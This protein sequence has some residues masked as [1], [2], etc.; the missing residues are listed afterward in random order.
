MSEVITKYCKRCRIWVSFKW[1]C[2]W[3]VLVFLRDSVKIWE[4]DKAN[5]TNFQIGE[6]TTGTP[7]GKCV[8]ATDPSLLH[9]LSI[10]AWWSLFLIGNVCRVQ[11]SKYS[12][13]VRMNTIDTAGVDPC[14][15]LDGTTGLSSPMQSIGVACFGLGLLSIASCFT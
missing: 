4:M 12:V 5:D 6:P 15:C 9:W 1:L 3:P 11:S 2:W 14:G 7:R 10:F 13:G 8:H